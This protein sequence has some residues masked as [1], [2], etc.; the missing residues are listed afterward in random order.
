M[1]DYLAKKG[2]AP[3]WRI[4]SLNAI[5]GDG[6]TLAGYGINPNGDVEGFVLEN[7]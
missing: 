1:D 7:F 4:G 6:K 3:G 5:S 2:L